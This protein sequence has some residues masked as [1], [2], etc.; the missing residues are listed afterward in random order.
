MA[1]VWKYG[2]FA[3]HKRPV[4]KL[5]LFFFFEKQIDTIFC[6]VFALIDP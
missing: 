2:F 6:F 5:L 4:I 3:T 1:S